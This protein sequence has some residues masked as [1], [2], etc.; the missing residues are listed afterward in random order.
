M[1]KP[2]FGTVAWRFLGQVIEEYEI[3]VE[4]TIADR[5]M[6]NYKLF[7]LKQRKY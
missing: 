7:Y 2:T 3:T 5:I 4:K 1:S 6:M